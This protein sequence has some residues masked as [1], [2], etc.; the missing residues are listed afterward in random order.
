MSGG[1]WDYRDSVWD[2]RESTWTLDRDLVGYE[3]E[4]PDG[5]LGVVVSASS[6]SAAAYLVVDAGP[7]IAGLRLVP[8][9]A[10]TSM[11]HDGRTVRIVLTRVQLVAA[12]AYEDDALDASVRAVHDHYFSNLDPR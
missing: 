3:V 9:G 5:H 4:A 6:S 11:H 12:P 2:Y 10:V 7:A 8:A 1:L